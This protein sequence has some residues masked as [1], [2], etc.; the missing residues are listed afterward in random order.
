MH[1][2]SKNVIEIRNVSKEYRLGTIGHGTLY[3]DLQSWW[4]KIR[5]HEDPNKKLFGAVNELENNSSAL[6][7][8]LK[9]LSLDI[10]KG[11]IVGVIGRN[12]AGKST[13]LKLLSRITTPTSGQIRIRGR[14]ASLL[15]V[16]TGFHSELTGRENVYLNGAIL[17]MTQDEIDRQF[18]Q[19]VEFSELGK[20]ID[21]PVKR[22]SSGM[23]VRLAFAVA[24]HLE[25][26]VLI[27][28]EVLAVGDVAFRKKCIGKM[29]GVSQQTEKTVLFVSHDMGAIRTLCNRVVVLDKGQIIFD[30]DVDAGVLKYAEMNADVSGDGVFDFSDRRGKYPVYI[31]NVKL[32]NKDGLTSSRFIA[33]DSM[34]IEVEIGGAPPQGGFNLEWRL[35][36]SRGDALAFGG[37]YA[38]ANKTYLISDKLIV[39]EIESLPLSSGEYFFTLMLRVWQQEAWTYIERAVPF[40]IF[41]PPHSDTGFEYEL[42]NSGPINLIQ[43]WR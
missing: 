27:V 15:E 20:F 30:G 3:R 12:G 40:E 43:T 18:D 23:I 8:A 34:V 6:F 26:E 36:S 29:Q 35:I 32:K 33:H 11:E 10:R 16:G 31:A 28:D 19:I 41:S 17:G 22:Y 9:K 13:L 14:I 38:L 4:A 25:S 1:N 21:T 24:A 7:F 5:G 42:W 2:N 39:C 37:S